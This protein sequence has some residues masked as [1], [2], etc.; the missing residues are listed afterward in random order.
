MAVAEAP[1]KELKDQIAG[2]KAQVASLDAGNV[3]LSKSLGAAHKE[4]AALSDVEA[5]N[6]N[7]K[8]ALSAA[9]AKIDALEAAGKAAQVKVDKADALIAA[10]KDAQAFFK[11]IG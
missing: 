1:L 3:H 8:A 9:N 7:L 2:L 11:L 5:E 6:S 10:A 4:L